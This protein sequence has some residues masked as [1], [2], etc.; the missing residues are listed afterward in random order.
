M[1]SKY[2]TY[3]RR[4]LVLTATYFVTAK[5]GQILGSTIGV[6]TI[7]WPAAGIALA[8]VQL[9][10][11]NLWPGIMAGVL[12]Y[13]MSLGTSILASIFIAIGAVFETILGSYLL[14]KTGFD[15]SLNRVRDVLRFVF[16]GA[17]LSVTISAMIGV[18]SLKL[19]GMINGNMFFRSLG[20]WLIGDSLG[21]LVVTPL[22]LVWTKYLRAGVRF[23]KMSVQIF[24]TLTF[25]MLII[26]S[27]FVFYT[28]APY[29]GLSLF[30]FTL[31][32][33]LAL[34]AIYCGQR[35]NVTAIALVSTIAILC[36]ALRHQP[37]RELSVSLLLIQ[38]FMAVISI[39]YMLIAATIAE[40]DQAQRVLLKK[41]FELNRERNQLKRLNRAKDEFIAV[42][43]HQLR[44]PATGIKIN[45]SMLRDG[46]FG[47]LSATQLKRVDSANEFNERQINIIED[48]LGVAQ[49]DTDSVILNKV[50]TNMD[51]LIAGAIRH[52]K[53]TIAKRGQTINFVHNPE[54]HIAKVDQNKMLMAIEN[55]IDN[56]SKYS[57][58]NKEITVGLYA[59]NH[60]VLAI[61]V[62][63]SGC[64]IAKKDL[65]KLFKK[66]S[67]IENELTHARGGTGLGL[68]WVKKIVR[69]HGGKISVASTL[70]HGTV[71]T[72]YL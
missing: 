33:L 23:N 25:T 6:V 31:T 5:L 37:A 8:A 46:F 14:K 15:S 9:Y 53:P 38:I 42:A 12:L 56:A 72:I 11:Y 66:F 40:R 34:I 64:G 19:C 24:P 70:G 26:M 69:L 41:T 52:C 45:L 44:T 54:S 18:T 62:R 13:E 39:S 32:P 67:R 59:K 4:V 51:T 61:E 63:D 16:Y 49:V 57:P 60:D 58:P 2:S 21:I 71:F 29:G 28:I 47:N 1:I 50:D 30:K 3:L 20:T 65:C 55:L 48:I 7:I 22:I 68:Y 10:G 35:G 43:S 27:F 36:T 17:A